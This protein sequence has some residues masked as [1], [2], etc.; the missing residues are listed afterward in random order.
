MSVVREVRRDNMQRESSPFLTAR[1]AS[2][3]NIKRSVD[4]TSNISFPSSSH[5]GRAAIN[6][7]S[8]QLR[9]QSATSTHQV[10]SGRP[11]GLGES[12]YGASPTEIYVNPRGRAART[13]EGRPALG[14]TGLKYANV[15]SRGRGRGGGRGGG[16][17]GG[18]Q[19]NFGLSR[20]RASINALALLCEPR[21]SPLLSS[22][23][24]RHLAWRRRREAGGGKKTRSRNNRDL[25][26][27]YRAVL[28]H[29][30]FAPFPI[31]GAQY[32]R[33][34]FAVCIEFRAFFD[35]GYYRTGVPVIGHSFRAVIAMR[36]NYRE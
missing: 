15:E 4:S 12:R 3:I 24:E 34:V 10:L 31:A 21:Y 1:A 16:G 5:R 18:G 6:Y 9:S 14:R 2:L 23:P 29:D 33:R 19:I 17:G 22:P 36:Y 25:C 35:S 27:H 7:L 13:V 28:R 20:G 32:S 30:S 8:R 26:I 11:G